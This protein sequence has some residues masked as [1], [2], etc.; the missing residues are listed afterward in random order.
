MGK[1]I[2]RYLSG[3][4]GCVV[5]EDSGIYEWKRNINWGFDD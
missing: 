2:M 5:I 3:T 4:I 1:C